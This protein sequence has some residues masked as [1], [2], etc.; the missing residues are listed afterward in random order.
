MIL[1]RL[2]FHRR[3]IIL[4]WLVSYLTIL[5]LPVVL[6]IGV[7]IESSRTLESEIHQ[8]NHFLLQQV[9]EVMDG[10][11]QAV[12]RLNIELTWNV[13]VQDLLYSNKY[14]SYPNEFQYDLYQISQD[15]K[16]YKSAYASMIDSF[17]IYV[18]DSKTV[19]LP[20]LTRNASL[21][22]ETV[23]ADDSFP[24]SKWNAMM[25]DGRFRGLLPVVRIGEDGLKKKSVAFISPYAGDQDHPIATNVI[26]I[27]QSRILGSIENMELFNEG[28]VLILNKDNQV[29]VSNSGEPMPADFPFDK[30]TDAPNFFYYTKNGQKFEVMYIPSAQSGLKYISMIPSR[31]YWEKAEHVR[32]LT[33]TSILVSLLGGGLLTTFFLRKNYNPVR[34][35]VQAFSKKAPVH[36]GKGVNEFLFIEQALDRTLTE[37]DNILLRMKQQASHPALEL[38]RPVAEGQ[39]GQP[40]S[41]E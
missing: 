33:Y 20:A 13:K 40:N 9:R 32:N 23:H 12:E 37:M 21:A 27:D 14:H 36:Y 3:S 35:L 19:I 39:A 15:L 29:L 26:M 34:R 22:Y 2:G 1:A 7:Y 16:L 31:L 8:A 6:S 10:H 28:H 41:G 11:F 18:A 4:T 25:N 30:L 38:H 17:Y 5:L 24:F